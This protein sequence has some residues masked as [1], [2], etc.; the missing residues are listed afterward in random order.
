MSIKK[1]MKLLLRLELWVLI[2]DASWLSENMFLS[3]FYFFIFCQWLN[4]VQ[5][6]N[7]LR[8]YKLVSI[9]QIQISH[10]GLLMKYSDKLQT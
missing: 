10:G 2:V 7:Y 3:A 8:D 1:Q 6:E 4:A 5:D 9:C